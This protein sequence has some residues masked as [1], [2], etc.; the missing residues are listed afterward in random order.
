M[1]HRR[2][3]PQQPMQRGYN[4]ENNK[5]P[6]AR[7]SSS[8]VGKSPRRYDDPSFLDVEDEIATLDSGAL[9]ETSVTEL[10]SKID[11]DLNSLS[12]L[13]SSHH[14]KGDDEYSESLKSSQLDY[15]D[16]DDDDDD[17]RK[18]MKVPSFVHPTDI[19]SALGD[20]SLSASRSS[21][22]QESETTRETGVSDKDSMTTF[23]K[24]CRWRLHGHHHV[25]R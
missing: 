8:A 7:L 9:E 2:E 20:I 22:S 19:E 15:D 5:T 11:A 17:S 13:T 21:V 14:L 23:S 12:L 10:L 1:A 3:K 6:G 24:V 4:N 25:G 16:E 18:P